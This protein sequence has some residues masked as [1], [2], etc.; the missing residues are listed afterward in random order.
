MFNVLGWDSQIL[1]GAWNKIKL[2]Q[3]KY[4]LSSAK[5]Q[6]LDNKSKLSAAAWLNKF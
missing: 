5:C 6:L 3:A 2:T 1:Y 4:E